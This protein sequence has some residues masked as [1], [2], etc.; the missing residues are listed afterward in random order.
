M[1]IAETSASSLFDDADDDELMLDPEADSGSNGAD[2]HPPQTPQRDHQQPSLLDSVSDRGRPET[3]SRKRG[4]PGLSPQPPPPPPP[5]PPAPPSSTKRPPPLDAKFRQGFVAGGKPKAAD[6]EDIIQALLLR[7]MAEYSANILSTDAF[8]PIG[9][10]LDWAARCWMSTCRTAK[11]RYILADRMA[12][13]ITKRGSQTRGRIVDGFRSVFATHYG[14]I[15][16]STST[17]IKINVALAQKL[18]FKASFHYKDVNNRL[19]FG[20]N[21]ILSD[22]RQLTT[23]KDRESLG[24][25]FRSH[26]D[27]ITLPNLAFDFAVLE[28]LIDEWS[29][30]S[31]IS[32]KFYEKDVAVSYRRHLTDVQSWSNFNKTVVENIRKKWSKRAMSSLGLVSTA[33]ISTNIDREQEDRMRDEMEGRTGATDSEP[34]VDE[35]REREMEE[36]EVEEPVVDAEPGGGEEEE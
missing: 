11:A 21:S 16:T 5:P 4:R 36:P 8:P 31:F 26:F 7:A 23:F 25:I 28:F 29:T 14:F 27:P 13:L 32:K 34:E 2:L 24:A 10:Q 19:G 6:Y 12:K 20:G 9:I 22:V 35:P 17:S 3:V 1:G 15:R 30:G 18:K 33:A